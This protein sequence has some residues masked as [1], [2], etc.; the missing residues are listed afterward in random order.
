MV[1][2]RNIL[3]MSII[4]GIL[5]CSDNSSHFQF[6]ISFC[7]LC[8][9][10]KATLNKVKRHAPQAFPICM[11]AVR[12]NR[13]GQRC[14]TVQYTYQFSFAGQVHIAALQIRASP[15]TRELWFV[16]N[17]LRITSRWIVAW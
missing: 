7:E 9:A 10:G 14:R 11:F 1:K 5:F 17:S 16:D 15:L 2:R 13:S 6:A 8:F 4:I 3:I 12:V